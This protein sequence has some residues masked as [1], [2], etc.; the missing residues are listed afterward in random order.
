M[1]P[2]K[3]L[4]NCDSF[5]IANSLLVS[6]TIVNA[7]SVINVS[8]RYGV[9]YNWTPAK[10]T[11]CNYCSHTSVKVD[12]SMVLIAVIE[13][14]N[15]CLFADTFKFATYFFVPNV[16]TPNG[17]RYNNSFYIPDLPEGTC[18]KIFDRRGRTV[19]E[20]DN[21]TND[22]EGTD[23]DGNSLPVDTYW[24]IIKNS[25]Y[26]LSKSGFVYLKR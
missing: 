15:G 19:Y 23:K 18:L 26:R 14:E 4:I 11:D 1:I 16:F 24:Y 25:G 7:G 5:Y 17:D 13:H 22:W 3:Q 12:S 20:S 8:A 9:A 6:D 21:Y 2:G 10:I